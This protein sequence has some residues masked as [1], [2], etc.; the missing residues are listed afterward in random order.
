MNIEIRQ[1]YRGDDYEVY[2]F[3]TDY[4][5]LEINRPNV[6]SPV[7]GE[8]YNYTMITLKQ[9]GEPT[10]LTTYVGLDGEQTKD[11]IEILQNSGRPE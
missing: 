1:D 7:S 9:N 10:N 2:V 3:R 11:L 4:G 5:T 8:D 6:N